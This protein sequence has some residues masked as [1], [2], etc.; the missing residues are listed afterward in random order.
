MKEPEKAEKT[1]IK[2]LKEPYKRIAKTQV[3]MQNLRMAFAL[4]V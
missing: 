1:L 3:P 4:N 2:E